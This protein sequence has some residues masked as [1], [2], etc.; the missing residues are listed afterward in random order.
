MKSTEQTASVQQRMQESRQ[1]RPRNGE[2]EAAT[3]DAEMTIR[4]DTA[5]ESAQPN[6][7]VTEQTT[8]QALAELPSIGTL[9]RMTFEKWYM[10]NIP[11]HAAALAYY[12]LFAVAP[13]L[14][15]AVALMGVIYGREVA[16]AQLVAQV[17]QYIHS[18]EAASL[19]QT[20]LDNTL[21][22]STSW[23][24]TVAGIIALI[25]G[26]SS[27]FGE[28]QVVLNLIWGAPLNPRNDIWGL[29]FGR[30][31]AVLMVGLS[32]LVIFFAL[33]VTIWFTAANDWASNVLHTHGNTEQW[34]YFFA[35]F[36]LTTLVFALIYK[37]V[38]NVAIAWHDVIIGAIATAFLISIARLLISWYLTHNR[39]GSV[40][41]AAGSLVILLLWV[42]YSAQIF[43]LG[44]E[45]TQVYGRTYG[46]WWR[47]EPLSTPTPDEQ[48]EQPE[49]N[50]T[51]SAQQMIMAAILPPTTPPSPAEIAMRTPALAPAEPVA[52]E[53][54]NIEPT[55]EHQ[56]VKVRATPSRHAWFRVRLPSR[57]RASRRRMA[58]LIALPI[59]ATRP[60]REVVLAISVIGALS[61]AAL[62]GIPWRKRRPEP[63]KSPPPLSELSDQ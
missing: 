14:L 54:L 56:A 20:V 29:I 59:R 60:L 1:A 36:L 15:L 63:T 24:V 62:F 44:A 19:V 4:P 40:Y 5:Q 57:L 22:T 37:F 10:D 51:P 46:S 32:G 39:I 2:E 31:L 23:W 28:L 9:L 11:R 3:G 58:Q 43:F 41:G 52:L 50:S 13:L 30:L 25:Y 18:A 53:V 21:P 27:V 12:T 45:F 34:A 17:Q 42:Y 7:Q 61:L 49:E 38:P 47:G 8:A 55:A 6:G 16:E 26:A 33:V 35:F 48:S